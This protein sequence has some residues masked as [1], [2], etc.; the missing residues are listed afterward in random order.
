VSDFEMFAGNT[1][2]IVIPVVDGV[3]AVVDITGATIR[4]ELSR[5]VSVRPSILQKTVG[6]GVT[7]TDG[8]GGIFEV[9]LISDD[10]EDLKGSFYH[11]AEVKLGG[12]IATVKAGTIKINPV[13]IDPDV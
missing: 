11:E 2:T 10:T 4:W 6:A 3:G 1:K 5:S 8:P 12:E 9:A 13:L 7:I